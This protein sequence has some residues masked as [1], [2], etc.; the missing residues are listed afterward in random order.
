MFEEVIV[1]AVCKEVTQLD[2]QSLATSFDVG[3]I[4]F[5]VSDDFLEIRRNGV[6]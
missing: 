3:N 4:L 2:H 1:K 5:G 6:D